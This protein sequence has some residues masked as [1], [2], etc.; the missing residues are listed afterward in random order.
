M[1]VLFGAPTWREI[2]RL[3]WSKAR[4]SGKIFLIRNLL[5]DD[6]LVGSM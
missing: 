3:G 1:S 6:L 4:P 5:T 2:G